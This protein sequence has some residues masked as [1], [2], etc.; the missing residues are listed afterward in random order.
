VG[1]IRQ[2]SKGVD[3]LLRHRR[4]RRVVP[5]PPVTPPSP[6]DPDLHGGPAAAA[7]D[8]SSDGVLAGL[9]DGSGEPRGVDVEPLPMP[10]RVTGAEE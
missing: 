5:P 9:V 7:T 1:Q 2:P 8:G 6:S 3:I 4:R 10:T